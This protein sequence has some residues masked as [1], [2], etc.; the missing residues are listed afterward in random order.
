MK[1]AS[2]FTLVELVIAL[3]ILGVLV[4]IAIPAYSSY[5]AQTKV[6]EAVSFAR[7]AK[8]SVSEYYQQTGSFPSSNAQVGLEPIIEGSSVKSMNIESG[9]VIKIV[10]EY[11][12]GEMGILTLAP[13]TN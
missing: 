1:C 6:S 10:V 2:G 7:V 8:L 11:A 9:G 12:H 3:V 13:T 5:I 4:S